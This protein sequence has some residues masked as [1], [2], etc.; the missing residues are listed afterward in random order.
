MGI[1][2]LA[3]VLVK[4]RKL[5][6]V[7]TLVAAV[8]AII[9]AM[10]APFYWKAN[11]TIV[12]ISESNSIGGFSTNLLDMMGGGLIKTQKSELAI[13]FIA[14]MKSRTFRERVINEFGLIEYFK[15]TKPHDHAMELALFK[16]QNK[17]MRLTYDQESYLVSISA[18]TRDQELSRRITQFYLDELDK[19]NRTTRMSKGRMKREFLEQQVNQNM[20][21]AD[22]LALVIRDFQIQ[23]K[24]IALDQQTNS[25]V[26]MYSESVAK[27]MQAEI[28]YELAR[29]Q[30]SESSPIVLELLNKKNL[31]QQKMK[32][33]ENSSSSLQP[34]YVIQIDK[35]PDLS[36][37]YAQ[38]M[39]NVEIKKKIIEYLY[40]QFELAKLDELKDMPS[41][42]I[43]DAPRTAGMRS[44]PKRAVL[45]VVITMAAFLAA[46]V[47]ALINDGLQHN[48]AQ[49]QNI[50]N[51]LRGKD[52]AEM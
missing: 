20:R 43:I 47:L 40:P 19:Y 50:I 39:I 2:D 51:T 13:D 45:V 35:I 21:E 24:S 38:L 5:I 16:L 48:K 36:M 12:P 52:T 18:E 26:S 41:F 4:N 6:I 23:N 46:C 7:I 31:L 14:I 11:S 28:E 42:E 32:D 30:Y 27:Y 33:L 9:Y 37:R 10:L 17:I 3:L 8:A 44:K 34:K 29:N 15:I 49:I 1:L 22:S 25:L